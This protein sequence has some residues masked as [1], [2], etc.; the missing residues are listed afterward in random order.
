MGMANEII[1]Y[2]IANEAFEYSVPQEFAGACETIEVPAGRYP[3]TVSR[4]YGQA[5]FAIELEGVSVYRAW[6]G[7]NTRI[8]RTPEP[9]APKS[10]IRGYELAFAVLEGRKRGGLVF[11]MAPGYEAR[12]IA[13]EYDGQPRQTAGIFRDGV[14]LK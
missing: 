12:K 4:L 5:H 6:F 9:A 8:N 3:V 14:E 11:E 7:T 1:A 13:F 2:A 10:S